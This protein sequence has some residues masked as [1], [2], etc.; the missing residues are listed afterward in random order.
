MSVL[1]LIDKYQCRIRTTKSL[2][3]LIQE[4]RRCE[5]VIRIFP[6]RSL[7]WWL[8]GTLLVETLKSGQRGAAT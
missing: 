7:G 6:S 4:I 5:K 2:E 3:R 8:I 1:A